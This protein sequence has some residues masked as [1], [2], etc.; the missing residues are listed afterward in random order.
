MHMAIIFNLA[1]FQQNDLI[2]QRDLAKDLLNYAN[3]VLIYGIDVSMDYLTLQPSIEEF[4]ENLTNFLIYNDRLEE[5]FGF[6]Y[7]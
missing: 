2:H 7:A 6:G 3:E 5:F 1:R 4:V